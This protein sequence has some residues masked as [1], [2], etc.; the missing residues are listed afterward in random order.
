M[1]DC[2]NADVR[3]LLPAY[4]HGALGAADRARVE[5]H[6]AGCAD[7]A[8][9]LSLIRAAQRALAPAPAV[10][11]ARIVAALPRPAAQGAGAWRPAD[12]EADAP[13]VASLAAR[14]AM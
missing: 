6:V 4:A 5:S 10:N 13:G 12:A 11:V 14:R 3:D 9:E 1:I 7:C 2:P 8:A